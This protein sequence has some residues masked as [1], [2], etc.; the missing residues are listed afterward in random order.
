LLEVNSREV[1]IGVVNKGGVGN[2]GGR[3]AWWLG[4]HMKGHAWVGY[5]LPM[6]LPLLLS[7]LCLVHA[8]VGELG[9]GLIEEGL[10]VFAASGVFEEDGLVNV[11]DEREV[12]QWR[13]GRRGGGRGGGG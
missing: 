11:E 12:R 4:T 9:D 8:S 6:L 2:E 13:L 10:D 7:L 3:D 1:W 5:P